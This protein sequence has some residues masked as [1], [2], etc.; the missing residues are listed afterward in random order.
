[1]LATCLC[2]F[3]HISIG[4]VVVGALLIAPLSLQTGLIIS[5]VA[6]VLAGLAL[7]SRAAFVRGLGAFGMLGVGYLLAP[8][9]IMTTDALPYSPAQISG[10]VLYAIG[11]GLLV[12]AFLAA[13]RTPKRAAAATSMSG[14]VAATGCG[15]CMVNG[16][17]TGLGHAAGL[18]LT[19]TGMFLGAGA[20]MAA[21][22]FWMGRI[23]PALLAAS[24]AA[25]A[26]GAP[27]LARLVFDGPVGPAVR[28]SLTFVGVGIVLFAFVHAY[29]VARER[30]LATTG[31]PALALARA[32]ACTS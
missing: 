24:G 13:Y 5:A 8:P 25:F 12:L 26:W 29:R 19:G 1:M 6:L 17:L 30:V 18:G 2:S 3:H 28:V 16:A 15:C 27:R 31:G 23:R 32:P 7:R 22:L 4:A 21:G 11:A 14:M 10:L 20:L 9:A